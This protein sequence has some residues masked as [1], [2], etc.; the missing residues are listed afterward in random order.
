VVTRPLGAS[1]ADWLGNRKGWGLG[2]GLVSLLFAAAML[3]VR[4]LARTG[5]DTPIERFG[6]GY[7]MV[8]AGGA[9]G[10][11]DLRRKAADRC[12]Y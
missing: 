8:T 2:N 7:L 12:P 11:P 6:E 9:G 10:R 4:H 3:I 5:R 1:V